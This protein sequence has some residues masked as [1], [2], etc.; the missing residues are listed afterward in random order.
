M[1]V[2]WHA[3]QNTFNSYY[4]KKILRVVLIFGGNCDKKMEVDSA[5]KQDDEKC[6]KCPCGTSF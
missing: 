6:L 5:S 4:I 1:I 3:G 2:I